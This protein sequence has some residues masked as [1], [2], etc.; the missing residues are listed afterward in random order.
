MTRKFV[1]AAL[2][3]GSAFTVSRAGLR[4]CSGRTGGSGADGAGCIRRRCRRHNPGHQP[5]RRS[6]GKDRVASGPGRGAPGSARRREDPAGESRS[7][8]EGRPRVR[9]QGRRL[10]LQAEGLR[11]VRCRLCRLPRRRRA[12]R[13][14][15][16]PQLP[17]TSASTRAPAAL[18]FGAE[19]TLPGRF[20]LQVRVQPRSR[21]GRLSRTSSSPTILRRRHSRFQ[22]GNFYPYSSLETMTSS[23]LG[24]MHGARFVHRCVQLQ[25]PPRHRASVL[26]QGDRQLPYPGRHLL[27]A[28]QRRDL[29]AHRLA[30]VAPCALH[31]DARLDPASRRRELPASLEQPGVAWVSSIA[32]VRSRRSPTSASSTRARLRRRATTSVGLEFAA[33][34]KSLHVA[35]EAQKSGSPRL[36][37]SRTRGDQRRS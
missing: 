1:I 19:G 37:R 31:A 26:R 10:H 8:L 7:D 14:G 29:H 12:P 6:P 17:A 2:L 11:S 18:V 28:D 9:R 33:I 30:G 20:R 16:R 21:H 24:S 13:Y 4:R 34:H 23:R 15:E 3:A 5:G 27:D 22:I 36:Q 25:P 32:P 35:A